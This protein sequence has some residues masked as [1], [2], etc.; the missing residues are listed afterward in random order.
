MNKCNNCGVYVYES[1]SS[2]PLCQ[3]KLGEEK[4]TVVKY[5]NY[6]D[7]VAHR[8][9]LRNI[10]LFITFTASVICIYINFFTYDR[11]DLFWS[12][13][14]SVSLL[15]IN[16]VIYLMHSPSKRFGAK[17]LLNYVFLSGYLI[18]IDF[19]TGMRLWSTN[20]VFP[21]LTIATIIFLTV[22]AIRSKRLFSEYFGYILSVMLIGVIP[23]II[24]LIG[25]SDQAWG[26]F[27]AIICCAIIALGL[28][29]FSDKTFK[30]ELRKRFHR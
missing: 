14:V 13:I 5:P 1:D 28:Y 9:L 18:V 7:I 3:T 27:V 11:G 12:V 26:A 10:P 29:L 30:A 19:F 16:E 20:Y 24:Y 6:K 2:C 15:Y 22:L 17:V 25:F 23:I 8:S 4:D 21:F